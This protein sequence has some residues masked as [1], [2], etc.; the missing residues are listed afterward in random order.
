MRLWCN[1]TL[2]LIACWTVGCVFIGIFQCRPVRGAWDLSVHGSCIDLSIFFVVQRATNLITDVVL[3]ALPIK[4]VATLQ[5]S[6]TKRVSLIFAFM[7]GGLYDTS[8]IQ[9][10]YD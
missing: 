7:M 6:I 5:T 1:I 8:P 10:E 2:G 3:L 4:V 9:S